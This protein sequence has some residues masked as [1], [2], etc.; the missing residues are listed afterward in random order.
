MSAPS[1]ITCPANAAVGMNSCIR[2]KVRINVD[3]PQP[4][5]PIKAV[6]DPEG[7]VRFTSESTCLVPNQACIPIASI[8]DAIALL[9]WLLAAR[10]IAISASAF[11]PC[12]FFSIV[13]V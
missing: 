3:F 2:F 1:S 7:N 13:M 5:G 8:S 4:E 9:L 10:F 6:T 11:D 12:I